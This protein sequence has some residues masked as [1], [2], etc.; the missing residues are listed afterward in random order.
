M[1][2]W[3]AAIVML[4]VAV[5]LPLQAEEDYIEGAHYLP[6]QPPVQT[7]APAGKVEVMELFWYG[8][9]HCYA[10]EPH[11]NEWLDDKPEVVSFKRVPAV[12]NPQWTLH[13]QAYFAAEQL[14]AVETIHTPMFQAIHAQRR[15]LI[16]P[17]QIV[18]FVSSLGVD[19][20]AFEQAMNS[21][22][23]RAKLQESYE[24]G[25]ASQS[26]GVPALVVAGK[27]RVTASLAGGY[28]EML[29]VV[30]YLVKKELAQ[31]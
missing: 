15:R 10:L 19:G 16:S 3:L 5:A 12:L 24:L 27:Y 26:T 31:Q 28:P 4:L 18:R 14:D 23:V 22:A 9:P 11:L 30:N 21:P 7:A 17:D 20:Q 25:R 6:I 13:A 1:K 8:C 29:D 2:Y